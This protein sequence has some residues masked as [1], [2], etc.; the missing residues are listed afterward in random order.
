MK[1][2]ARFVFV[3]LVIVSSAC[4]VEKKEDA[5]VVSDTAAIP[6][7]TP[8]A[9]V[10]PLPPAPTPAVSDTLKPSRSGTPARPKAKTPTNGG[11]RDSAVQPVMG[12]GA[13]GKIKV[14]KK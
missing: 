5:A 8:P 2:S 7:V 13:D 1:N 9:A 3:C 14:I 11:E 10:A 6:V 12:I 4:T